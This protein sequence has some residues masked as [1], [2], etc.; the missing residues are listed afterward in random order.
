M[1]PVT[2]KSIYFPLAVGNDDKVVRWPNQPRMRLQILRTEN[3]MNVVT[4]C[5]PFVI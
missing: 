3:P 2:S 1:F 4:V 5:D